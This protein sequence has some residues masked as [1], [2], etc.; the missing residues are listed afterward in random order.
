MLRMPLPLQVL[1]TWALY[2]AWCPA[3]VAGLRRAPRAWVPRV[4]AAAARRSLEVPRVPTKKC[5]QCP[6]PTCRVPERGLVTLCVGI[7]LSAASL[8]PHPCLHFTFTSLA[9]ANITLLST[10]VNI[11]SDSLAGSHRASPP[12]YF[13]SQLPQQQHAGVTRACA[14]PTPSSISEHRASHLS[15]PPASSRLI[16]HIL[17]RRVLFIQNG[18]PF[19]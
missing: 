7:S 19:D 15:E 14:S 2:S 18:W 1:E 5:L 12:E 3:L 17:A 6:L 9:L 16:C 8:L 11:F 13:E 4:P 10:G